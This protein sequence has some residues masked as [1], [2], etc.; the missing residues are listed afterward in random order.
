MRTRAQSKSNTA[1]S[2]SNSIGSDRSGVSRDD[3]APVALT[4]GSIVS[5][6]YIAAANA[7][8]VLHRCALAI[9]LLHPVSNALV[10]L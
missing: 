8:A 5:D 1:S 7:A 4:T 9:V 3:A 2:S 6:T 10:A